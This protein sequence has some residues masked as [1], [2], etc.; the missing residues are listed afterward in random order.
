M[1][2]A[3]LNAR[4]DAQI[5]REGDATLARLGVSATE[6]IRALWTYLAKTQSLPGFMQETDTP[7]ATAVPQ[8][9]MG[10]SGAGMALSLAREQ[11]LSSDI[12]SIGYDELRDLAFQELLE[13]GV[14]H[15]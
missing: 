2:V 15:A 12:G 1:E 4:I 10:G 11:G 3:Q 5:K 13:E 6:A 8:H 9:D 14:Y 7:P